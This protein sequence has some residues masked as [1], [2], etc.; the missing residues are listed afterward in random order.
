MGEGVRHI[1]FSFL[2]FILNIFF[3]SYTYFNF[4]FHSNKKKENFFFS[5]FIF[6][7]LY[8]IS[9][10]Q[11]MNKKMEAVCVYEKESEVEVV[12]PTVKKWTVVHGK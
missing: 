6:F 1:V 4:F 11:K 9:D 5:F 7:F 10:E 8:L 12:T 2:I 3:S